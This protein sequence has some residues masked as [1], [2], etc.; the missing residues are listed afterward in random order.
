MTSELGTFN[1]I[2][3]DAAGTLFELRESVGAGYSAVG[4]RF[5]LNLR[6]GPTEEAFR[7][8][9]GTMPSPYP[10]NRTDPERHWWEQLVDQILKD[11]G[12]VK[13]A[14]FFDDLWDY[15]AS[16]T[17]WRLFPEVEEVLS[18]LLKANV[19]LILVTNFDERIHPIIRGLGIADFFADKVV[20]SA[21]ARSRKPD[22]GIFQEAI[23]L[24]P[25]GPILHVGDERIADWE[26]ARNAGLAAFE[27][28]RPQR[29][30]RDLP[31]V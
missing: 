17:V 24:A 31:M 13:P 19:G 20:T 14:G 22:P 4:T 28:D 23:A 9:F 7:T 12:E 16:P 8:H 2:F 1:T 3:F 6:P 26:G 10:S 29:S 27:L 18:A 30:L 5:G 15:Y 11:L 25:P 21:S